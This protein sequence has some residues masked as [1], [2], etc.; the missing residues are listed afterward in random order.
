MI[1][2]HRFRNYDF[3][4]RRVIDQVVL[5]KNANP[6]LKITDLSN[7]SKFLL[8]LGRQVKHNKKMN[9]AVNAS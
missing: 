1:F 7:Q 6:R 8:P 3:V 5:A 4:P 2:P 9:M